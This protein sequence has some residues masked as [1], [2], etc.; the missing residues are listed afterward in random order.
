MEREDG[1][2][3]APGMNDPNPLLLHL[4]FLFLLTGNIQYT[5][6]PHTL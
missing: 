4:F 6:K 5:R 1:M 2:D 3:P